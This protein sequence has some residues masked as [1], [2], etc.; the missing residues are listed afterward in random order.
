MDLQRTLGC[1]EQYAL[2]KTACLSVEPAL[3]NYKGDLYGGIH[4]PSECT[5]DCLKVCQEI[6]RLLLAQGVCIKENT[7]AQ[8][9][10]IENGKAIAVQ[11]PQA[12]I[13]A[14]FFV[15]AL[16]STSYNFAKS[17]GLNLPLYP[18]KGYS[19]TLDV[20]EQLDAVPLVSVT[21]ALRKVVF[22]RIGT[23]L[24]VA[25]MV[26][27]SG[28]N[29]SVSQA[30][31]DSLVATARDVFP[32]AGEYLQAQSWAGLRP[33]TPAGIP[34]IGTHPAAP[35]N[36]LLNTGHGALGFTLAFGSAHRISQHLIQSL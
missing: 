10:M 36:I 14:D 21:D 15:L 16:G 33:A 35:S 2:T 30:R 27:M 6:A 19:I 20:N 34:L 22:A 13:S 25:G 5:A 17:F 3:E 29:T 32:L 7:E 31:I 23:R 18:L 8:K 12:L 28:W 11:T 26:E 4:T 1:A 9:M 24:R